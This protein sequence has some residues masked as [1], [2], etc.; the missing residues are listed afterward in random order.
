[1]TTLDLRNVGVLFIKAL[2]NKL[3][4]FELT[5]G[6]TCPNLTGATATFTISQS[7]IIQTLTVGAG[8]TITGVNKIAVNAAPLQEGVYS[9]SFEIRPVSGAVIRIIHQIHVTNE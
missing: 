8:L 4:P 2:A 1:M 7:A 5:G 9:Y 6:V 3:W